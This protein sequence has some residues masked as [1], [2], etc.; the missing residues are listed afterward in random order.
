MTEVQ[1]APQDWRELAISGYM[2]LVG[3]LLTRRIDGEKVYALRAGPQH[4]NAIGLVH[5][6][7]IT[8]LFDQV[9]ALEAWNAAGRQPAVTVQ[10]DTRFLEAARPGDLL[11]ARAEVRHKTRSLL[12]VDADL[13]RGGAIIATANAVMKVSRPAEQP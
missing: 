12:F 9:M 2:A 10:I 6:G 1:A 5:G 13:R 4:A 7:V 8:G 3:P 11:E